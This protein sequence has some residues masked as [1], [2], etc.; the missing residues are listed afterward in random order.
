MA[1][2]ITVVNHKGG[3]GK[4]MTVHNLCAALAQLGKK[5]LMV[6]ADAQCNLTDHCV[7]R[8]NTH[9]LSDYLN[10]DDLDFLPVSVAENLD[11]LPGSSRL[12]EDSHEIE[13]AIEENVE[14]GTHYVDV[15]LKRVK[16]TYDYV[17][18]DS[19]PGSGPILVNVINAADELVIPIAD[20][21]SIKGAKKLTQIIKA[22]GKKLKGH[23]L[24]TKQAH[25]AVS[26]QIKE[27]LTTQSAES[28]YH[29][30]IR[31]CEDLNKAAAMG[32]SIYEF[33]PKSNGAEDYLCL[34]KELV[35]SEK[36]KDMPF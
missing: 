12:D 14:E 24:L 28:L 30:S 9:T 2:V 11:L 33:A 3:V 23:Y 27:M 36:E 34:A 16:E 6:D 18:I 32:M 31:Q 15:F 25:T 13:L 22:T 1:K 35:G 10:D 4:T 19:A 26:K 7:E 5:V 21:D 8:V 29:T 17:V 20:K